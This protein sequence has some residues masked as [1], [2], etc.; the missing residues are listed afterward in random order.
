M[1]ARAMIHS[2]SSPGTGR[3]RKYS[4]GTGHGH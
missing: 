1:G 3:H 4:G 2:V